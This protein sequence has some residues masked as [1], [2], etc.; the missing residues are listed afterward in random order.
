MARDPDSQG[1]G[2][3]DRLCARLPALG[4]GHAWADLAANAHM[5]GQPSIQENTARSGYTVLAP[6]NTLTT[7]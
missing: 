3:G 5:L 6:P 4:V 2:G 7:G 1:G